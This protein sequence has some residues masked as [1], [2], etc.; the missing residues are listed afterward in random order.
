[1][2]SGGF[3]SVG[4]IHLHFL[5][6]ISF[7]MG[8]GL[9]IFQSVVLGTLSV[10]FRG[11]YRILRR[12][13]LMTVCILFSVF[14]VLRHVSNPWSAHQFLVVFI[15]SSCL[16]VARVERQSDRVK[17]GLQLPDVRSLLVIF[18]QMYTRATMPNTWEQEPWQRQQ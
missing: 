12:H 13:L 5:F 17:F 2:V 7:F 11:T 16:D 18:T 10:H 4:P 6:F 9:V 15:P 3:L 1:M 14:Y 8:S